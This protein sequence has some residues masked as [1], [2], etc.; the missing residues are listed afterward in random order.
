MPLPSKALWRV[1]FYRYRIWQW[2]VVSTASFLGFCML[3][4]TAQVQQDYRTITQTSPTLFDSDQYLSISKRV[5]TLRSLRGEPTFFETEEIEGLRAQP[6][7][8]EVVTFLPSEF[9][10]VAF[11]PNG[12]QFPGFAS[13]IFFEALPSQ[14]LD[15][16]P[17]GFAWPNA[18]SLVPVIIPRNYLA[19]YNFGFAPSQGMPQV[20]ENAVQQFTFQLRLRGRGQVQDYPCKIVGFT[21]R[22]QTLLVPHAFLLAANAQYGNSNRNMPSRLLLKTKDASSPA[23]VEYLE[24]E[25]LQTNQD[26]LQLG[27][28]SKIMQAAT[29]A[30]VAVAALIILLSLLVFGFSMQVHLQR[31]REQLHTLLLMGYA[32]SSI[33]MPYLLVSGTIF[34]VVML[35]S[36]GLAQS[37][38]SQAWAQLDLILPDLEPS[39][40]IMTWVGLSIFGIILLTQYLLLGRALKKLQ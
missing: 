12:S 27:K 14:Y 32:K 22:I 38:H 23:L 2:L 29:G 3:M 26:Q 30:V 21:D 28:V 24:Q 4:L 35:A 8:E 16:V 34:L 40:N 19:L 6:F 11:S 15:V 5:N 9:K 39:T 25:N 37:L 10:M 31:N 1:L 18:D 33:I 7:A 20:S 36:L 17:E 13:D